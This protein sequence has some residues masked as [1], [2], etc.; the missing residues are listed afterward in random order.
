[1]EKLIV[2]KEDQF[3]RLDIFLEEKLSNVTR[4]KIKKCIEN[5]DILVNDKSQKAG[6]K[7][8][9]NDVI[10]YIINQDDKLNATP[11][12]IPLDIKFENDNL[13]VINKPSGMVVHPAAGN[14]SGT[15][16]N[17]LCGYTNSLSK[18]NGDFRPGIVHRLD[19]DTS[20]L[21]IVAKNDVAHNN[22]ALQIKDKVCKRYYLALLEGNLKQDSGE[23]ETNLARSLKDRKKFE[24]CESTKGK[25]AKT[26]YKVIERFSGYCLVEFELKTGRTHQIR[27]HA[28]YLGHPVVGDNT[29]GFKNQL[30]LNGQLLHAYK[31]EFFEPTTNEKI[32]VESQL[33]EK[34]KNFLSKLS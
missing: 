2:N 4:S 16:V 33:P 30:K 12:D 11:E 32:V 13:I 27:V 28:K 14:Y 21:L 3:K 18:V 1:M 10:V 19:K 26:L 24:V 5:N 8:K 25:Y 17:A 23:V 7:V 34:F 9:L 6:Y 20:G 29:Y 15:L 31:L 22:L